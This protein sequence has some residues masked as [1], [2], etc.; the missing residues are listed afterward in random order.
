MK[1]ALTLFPP[2]FAMQALAI[3]PLT[4]AEKQRLTDAETAAK[5]APEMRGVTA[6]FNAERKT[7]QL[8][9]QKFPAERSADIA[10]SFRKATAVY[11]QAK[12]KAMLSAVPDIAPLLQ[13]ADDLAKLSKRKTNEGETLADSDSTKNDAMRAIKDEPGLPR[14][15]LIGDSVSIGYTLQVRARLKGKANVHRIPQNGGA[16]EVGLA[17]MKAWLRGEKWDVIHFNFGLHDAKYASETTQRATRD[18][19]LANLQALIAQM[20]AT[21]ARLIFATTTPVPNGGVLSPTRKFDDVPA[22]NELAKALMKKNDVAIDDLYAVVL[23][24]FEK[25]GRANDV[26]FQPAG[27]EVLAAAVAASIKQRLSPNHAP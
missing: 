7:Y 3:E 15:L 8:D 21:G 17:N 14:V 22:R 27:Y 23:P 18:E 25:V 6:A 9:R 2:L 24:V 19:Y 5:R 11:E 12:R 1:L 26:H 4:D 10:K 20:K 13:R 16:T